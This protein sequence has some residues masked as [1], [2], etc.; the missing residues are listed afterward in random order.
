[1]QSIKKAMNLNYV[2]KSAKR[3]TT[4]LKMGQSKLEMSD[5]ISTV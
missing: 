4:S 3:T 1:M 5:P 2:A